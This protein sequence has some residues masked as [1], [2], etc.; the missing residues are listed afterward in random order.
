MHGNV[1]EWCQDWYDS[2]LS[3]G[4][5]P[6]GP[7]SGSHRVFRGGSWFNFASICRAAN[8]YNS[9]P[10]NSNFD[11]GFRVARSSVP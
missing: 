2:E 3:G 7:A 5:D 8:R 10:S 11:F 6:K 1:W 9:S 4:I